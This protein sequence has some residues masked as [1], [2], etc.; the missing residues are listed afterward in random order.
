[1]L[2]L[3]ANV[4]H[5]EDALVIDG[6]E[7]PSITFAHAPKFEALVVNY[8]VNTPKFLSYWWQSVV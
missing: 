1:M 2:E 4:L 3:S 5:R 8:S 7:R 6:E